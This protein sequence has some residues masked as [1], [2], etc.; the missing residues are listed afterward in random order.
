ML[1][2]ED[3][4]ETPEYKVPDDIVDLSFTIS[5]KCL[6]LDHAFALSDALHAALPWLA[7]EADA[8]VH[9]IHG[10]E[11]GNGWFRPVDTEDAILHLSRRTRMLLRMPKAR[12]E[13]AQALSGQQLDVAGYA[14]SIGDATIKPLSAMSTQFARH[15]IAEPDM[16]EDAFVDEVAQAMRGLGIRVTKLL[17][18]RSHDL[19]GSETLVHTRSVMVADLE[20]EEAVRL[21]QRG[22]GAGRKF[23]CGL[24][25]PHKGIKAVKETH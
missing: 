25:L 13:D 10:A 19:K 3:K 11:S 2:Q 7:D 23:G 15:V 21:Q 1:W 22:I 24:F 12:I 17:C 16:S 20:P 18:G 5:C 14:L 6:P 4:T 8:G 9:L